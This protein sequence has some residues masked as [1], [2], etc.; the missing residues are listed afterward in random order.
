MVLLQPSSLIVLARMLDAF[1][2]TH[3]DYPIWESMHRDST[4]QALQ[5]RGK[6]GI[7]LPGF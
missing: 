2:R 4:L 7:L 3:P 5:R 1:P 6:G